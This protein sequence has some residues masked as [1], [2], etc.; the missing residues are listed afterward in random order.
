MST[1]TQGRA[2]EHKVRDHMIAAGW[3]LISRSAGSKGPADLVMAS[4]E[5]GLALVQ[6][7][8]GLKRLGPT[9]RARL[10]HAARLSSALPILATVTRGAITYWWV[11]PGPASTWTEWS[12]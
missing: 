7:G 3:E 8:T 6:V 11:G 2:R 5:H 4:E 1:A 9:E 10:R 12:P